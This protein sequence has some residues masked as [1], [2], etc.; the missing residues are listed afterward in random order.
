M[1]K[2]NP[3]IGFI[4]QGWIGKNY[5]DSFEDCGFDVVRYSNEKSYRANKEAIKDC[6]FVFIAVPTPTTPEGP[7]ESIVRDVLG[8]VSKGKI[9][10]IKSTILPGTTEDLQK[11]NP[12]IFVL[13]SPEFLSEKSARQDVENPDC[14]I[15]GIPIDNKIYREKAEFLKS[16]LPNAPSI[17]CSSREAEF[18]KYTHNIHGFVEIIYTNILFD[19]SQK[20]KV[21][22]SLVKEFMGYDKFMTDRYATPLH[23][24]GHGGKVGRGAG[25]H[26]FIKD[27]AAFRKLYEEN[28]E[29]KK[30]IDFL[31]SLEEK[32][33]ELLIS[34]KKDLGLLEEVYGNIS[35]KK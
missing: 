4:G 2:K 34:T 30:S 16:I 3:K 29:N 33:I 35:N 6:E 18:I 11:N 25:G 26:C 17:I 23:S 10:V 28:I 5:A 15:I 19:L 9:A 32:N 12:N 7:D 31:K 13:N 21:D 24:S 1:D 20:L 22:W 27:F 8:I 14:N